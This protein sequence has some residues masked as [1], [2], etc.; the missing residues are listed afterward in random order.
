M[1]HNMRE[2]NAIEAVVGW[3]DAMRRGDFGAVSEWFDPQVIWRG[4]PDEAICRDRE[5][6]LAMLR[7]SFTPCPDDPER[8][9]LEP[10]L[11]GAEASSSSPPTQR[12]WCSGR[13]CPV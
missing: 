10:G 5:D 1:S 4:I 7:D 12:P 9:E 2:A 3:L 6:V 13:R 11:R 8:H